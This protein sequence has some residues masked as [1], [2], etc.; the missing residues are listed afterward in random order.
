M[1]NELAREIYETNVEKGWWE[2][3]ASDL[4]V[5]STKLALAHS[6]L[7]EALEGFR[8]DLMDT[9]LPHRK[10]AEVELAD[11][12][13][14]ILDLAASQNFD[15]DGAIAEKR[16]YNSQREDHKKEV[17]AAKFGKAI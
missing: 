14:R 1:L 17:R 2:R 12:I 6:E 3:G 11:T 5:I 7:S 10:M 13:I 9:H 8:K 15:L 16:I 4:Y